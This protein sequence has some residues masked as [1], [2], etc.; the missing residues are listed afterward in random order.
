M[1][2]RDTGRRELARDRAGVVCVHL[3]AGE[4]ALAEPDHVAVAQ[5]DG[6]QDL[7]RR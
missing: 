3:L 4:V 6:G 1:N 2:P 5:V 7:E